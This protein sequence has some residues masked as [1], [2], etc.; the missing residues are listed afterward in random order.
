MSDNVGLET[1]QLWAL[2]YKRKKRGTT[3]NGFGTQWLIGVKEWNLCQF[4][5]IHHFVMRE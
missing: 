1:W 5:R 4:S 2:S 3:K